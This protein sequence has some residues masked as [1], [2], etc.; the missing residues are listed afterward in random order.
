M[1]E[2]FKILDEREH[3]LVR[4]S[5]YIGSTSAEM[6]KDYVDGVYTELTIVPGLIKIINEIIDNSTDEFIRTGGKFANRITVDIGSPLDPDEITISDNGR[7]I[8]VEQ[9]DGVYKPEIAWTR[10]RAGSNFSDD[11]NRVTMGMNGVGSFATNVFSTYFTGVTSD[12]KN[13]IE[14]KCSNNGVVD[15]SIVTKT[16]KTS[17]GTKVSFVPDLKKLGGLSHI[18]K[19]HLIVIKNR[20]T[21][22]SVCFPGLTFVFNGEEIKFKSIKELARQYGEDSLPYDFGGMKLFIANSGADQEFRLISYVN[23][24]HLKNGGSHVDFIIFGIIDALRPLIKKKHKIEV[25]PGQIRQHL[26]LGVYAAGFKNLKF[27]SQTK[28]RLTNSKVEIEAHINGTVD[29][30]KIAKQILATDSI[31]MPII[32]AILAKKEFADRM[33]LA[34]SQKNAKK[35]KIAKHIAATSRNPHDKTLFIMEGGSAINSL[36]AVRNSA[37]HGGYPLKGKVMNVRGKKPV[38]IIKNKELAE[39]MAVL[40][41]NFGDKNLQLNY[42]RICIMADAD[43]DGYAISCLLINFFSLWPELFAEGRVNIVSTPKYIARKG[44]S[45][46]SYYSTEEYK[47]A[48]TVGWDVDYI[49]GLGTLPKEAYKEIINN[50]RLTC[51]TSKTDNDSK[52]LEMAFGDSADARKL[53]LMA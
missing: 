31:V 38:D 9:L 53:W 10:A 29:F 3:I 52:S 39:L 33:A 50:P 48:N 32:E 1:S 41:L 17:M 22:L 14:V 20:L 36:I 42:G 8:P 25:M 4:P 19:D 51:V 12:G 7:G 37:L 35:V 45:V 47:A 21:N 28:E 24:L 6:H 15:S 34:K 43:V 2:D 13:R 16:N 23:G 26:L 27:D 49:K 5:M 46:V 44:K 18:T 30:T 40:G 11:A